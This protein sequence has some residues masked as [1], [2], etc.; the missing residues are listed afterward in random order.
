LEPNNQPPRLTKQILDN[1]LLYFQY[2]LDKA[3]Y[4][5]K[6]LAQVLNKLDNK[7]KSGK[8]GC[9]IPVGNEIDEIEDL[10]F[11]YSDSWLSASQAILDNG[12]GSEQHIKLLGL[13]D[14]LAYDYPG[15]PTY[16]SETYAQLIRENGAKLN[17][18]EKQRAQ[19]WGRVE[20]GL[21]IGSKAGEAAS[22]ALL[23][24]TGAG[25]GFAAYEAATTTGAWAAGKTILKAGAV[26]GG[27]L[28]AQQVA[29]RAM[30][31]ADVPEG[32]RSAIWIAVAIAG[33]ILLRR[34]VKKAKALQTAPKSRP[35]SPKTG[36]PVPNVTESPI[37]AKVKADAKEAIKHI[38]DGTK[39]SWG[40]KWG[41]NHGNYEG[42]L[43]KVDAAGNPIIYKEYYLPKSPGETTKWGTNR[44]VVG[45]DGNAYASTTHYGQSGNPPFVHI[46]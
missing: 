19:F 4:A 11:M 5:K 29:D 34:Q 39:P 30:Q 44:L 37:P 32:V 28:L 42:N 9:P 43:P 23:I 45:S 26:V 27:T 7:I 6:Q 38:N 33:F 25:V 18:I 31:K 13:A 36:K 40:G 21:W 3:R 2:H 1:P 20:T 46:E 35:I 8:E 24:I 22:V 10:L 12:L 14:S 17:S 41:A 15:L 16:P